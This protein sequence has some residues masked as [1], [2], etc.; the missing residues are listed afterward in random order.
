MCLTP[1]R[2]RLQQA[3]ASVTRARLLRSHELD[4]YVPV[5][6]RSVV[7]SGFGFGEG[8]VRCPSTDDLGAFWLVRHFCLDLIAFEQQQQVLGRFCYC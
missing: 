1:P 5:S 8:E 4:Y 7:P 6:G 2:L 3:R